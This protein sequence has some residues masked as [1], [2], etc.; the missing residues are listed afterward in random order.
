MPPCVMHPMYGD[1]SVRAGIV[2]GVG[3]GGFLDGIVLHQIANWHTMGSAVLP[4]VTMEAMRANMRWDGLFHAFAWLVTLAGA[5]LLLADAHRGRRLPRPAAFSGQ[6][7]LGWGVFNLVEGVVDHHLLELHHVRD[8]PAHVPL[9]DWLFLAIAGAG[10]IVLGWWLSRPRREAAVAGVRRVS[11]TSPS[12]ASPRPE[13]RAAQ[14]REGAREARRG[15]EGG[16][17]SRFPAPRGD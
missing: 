6:L 11:P 17:G 16:R 7:V 15:F 12:P 9:L 3:L 1:R 8:L 4:P 10:F 5:Y 2:L 13:P 14:G